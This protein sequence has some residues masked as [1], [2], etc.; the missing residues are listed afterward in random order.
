MCMDATREA[1]KVEE[2]WEMDTQNGLNGEKQSIMANPRNTSKSEKKKKLITFYLFYSKQKA[3]IHELDQPQLW[4][5]F[6]F[7]LRFY[8]LAKWKAW[9]QPSFINNRVQY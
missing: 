9:K 5:N 8:Q 1:M 3:K 7:P 4:E 2:F 6:P